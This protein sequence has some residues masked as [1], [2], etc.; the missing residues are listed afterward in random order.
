M[1]AAFPRLLLAAALLAAAV[2]GG[3]AQCAP[4]C[5]DEPYPYP[6]PSTLFDQKACATYGVTPGTGNPVAL[7]PFQTSFWI[8]PSDPATP[9]GEK[10]FMPAYSSLP[11]W[12]VAPN[13]KIKTI[14]LPWH[15]ITAYANGHFCEFF[16][17]R[18]A[19]RVRALRRRRARALTSLCLS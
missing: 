14:M 18:A 2:T 13:P 19:P 3:A 7:K 9:A 15:G 11:L 10:R 8:E 1:A 17:A 12:G 6:V 16:F 4:Y 5:T